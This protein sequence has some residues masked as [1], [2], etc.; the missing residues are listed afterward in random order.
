MKK[1]TE[2]D[3]E[4]YQQAAID[5]RIYKFELAAKDVC[6][7]AREGNKY[8]LRKLARV[9]VELTQCMEELLKTD[10]PAHKA[11]LEC[12]GPIF[13][14]LPYLPVLKHRHNGDIRQIQKRFDL[15]GVG[16]KLSYGK[17]GAKFNPYTRVNAYVRECLVHAHQVREYIASRLKEGRDKTPENALARCAKIKLDESEHSIDELD[18]E[19]VS[20]I[21][22]LDQKEVPIH[23]AAYKLRPL[24]KSKASTGQKSLA[25]EWA[26]KVLIPLI[27][28]REPSLEHFANRM[29]WTIRPGKLQSDV[30]NKISQSLA[31]LASSSTNLPPS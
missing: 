7:L 29:E 27:R 9:A 19:E 28:L 3:L 2:K 25:D 6:K 24:A 13:S 16:S 5:L 1:Q 17:E 15:L 4:I 31:T 12:W 30:R 11:A 14:G 20:I 21:G 22:W 18:Q 10:A 8:G 26:D 23:L